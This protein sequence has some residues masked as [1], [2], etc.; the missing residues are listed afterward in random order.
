MDL[1]VCHFCSTVGPVSPRKLNFAHTQNENKTREKADAIHNENRRNEFLWF[2]KDEIHKKRNDWI[3]LVNGA[4]QP[5]VL[6]SFWVS[7]LFHCER[8]DC[9]EHNLHLIHLELR[10]IAVRMPSSPPFH[11]TQTMANALSHPCTRHRVWETV[12]LDQCRK[13]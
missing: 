9:P 12:K 13:N 6:H 3:T 8:A 2:S 10:T 1:M 4:R 7:L 11:V 5:P